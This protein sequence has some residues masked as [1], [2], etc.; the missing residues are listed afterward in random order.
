MGPKAQ[1]N[2][3]QD[4]QDEPNLRYSFK[5]L[6]SSGGSVTLGN[7]TVAQ[8][9]G[10]GEVEWKMT[11]GKALTLKDVRHV[12]DVRRNL[13]SGSSL[14]KQGYKIVMESNKIVITRNNVFIGKGYHGWLGHVSLSKIKRLMDLK[15]I[16]KS[17]VDL[18]HKCEVCVQAKQTRNSFKP[19]ERN[20]LIL[21]LIHSDMCDSNRSPTR[22]GNKYFVRFIDDFS[23]YCHIYL[24]KTKDEVFDKLKIYIS[25]V[26]NPLEKKIKRFR[27][28]RGGEYTSNEIGVFCEE[29]GILHE[30]TPHIHPNLMEWLKGKIKP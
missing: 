19:V 21:E 12:P 14:V 5:P 29:H 17:N 13:I 2:V 1:V 27:Y 6:N 24:I 23:R 28:D 20:T 8:V 3:D 11:S 9:H 30:V 22:G 18:K 4:D 16:P 7:D 26:E 10:T 25:E 15:Q